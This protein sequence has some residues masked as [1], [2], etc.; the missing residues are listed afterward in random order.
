MSLD[1]TLIAKREVGVYESN[2]THN[3]TDM[4]D[5]ARIYM[6]LWR[7]DEIGITHAKQLIKPL[8]KGLKLLKSDRKKFEKFNPK[9]G[10]GSYESL[11]E[12]VEKYLESCKENPDAKVSVSV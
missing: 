11:V 3:L 8:T 5:A 7:P 6:P 4:A 10:W 9:N 12:F 1:V 2:I